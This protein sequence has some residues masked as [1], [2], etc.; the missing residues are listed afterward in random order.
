[1][2]K[3]KKMMI[4]MMITAAMLATSAVTSFAVDKNAPGE[5]QTATEDNKFIEMPSMDTLD[6]YVNN[7]RSDKGVKYSAE[8][9]ILNHYVEYADRY[10]YGQSSRWT[11]KWW[12]NKDDENFYLL[13]ETESNLPEHTK[14]KYEERD[15]EELVQLL[16]EKGRIVTRMSKKEYEQRSKQRLAVVTNTWYCDRDGSWYLLDPNDGHM[17]SGLVH[18]MSTDSW[19]YLS[20][21][22]DGTFGHM[23]TKDGLFVID[24]V[25]YRL[26]FNQPSK[27]GLPGVITKGLDHIKKADIPQIEVKIPRKYTYA[28]EDLEQSWLQKVDSVIIQTAIAA[29]QKKTGKKLS[30]NDNG[31][32]I[33]AKENPVF[34]RYYQNKLDKAFERP[35]DKEDEL[36]LVTKKT[37]STAK[38]SPT[39]STG[40]ERYES[41]Y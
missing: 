20:V 9:D 19:Y 4:V 14:I 6:T 25:T 38:N 31:L 34:G 16:D 36:Q 32:K 21:T 13:K 29:Y 35:E 27:D 8:Q 11:Q 17:V 24:D 12:L 15:S 22:H 28:D 39:Q 3:N 37:K 18:D 23:Q 2:K 30:N 10:V 33:L 40:Y 5:K 1:M 41:L 7:K 26:E